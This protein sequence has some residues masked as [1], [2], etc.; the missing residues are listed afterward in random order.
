MSP[1]VS[2][3]HLGE[4]AVAFR[5]VGELLGEVVLP[6]PMTRRTLELGAA[7]SPEAAC[8]PFKYTLG[9]FIE[10]LEAG[11][12]VIVQAGGGCRLG[13]YGEVQEAILRDLGYDFG[14]MALSNH[15]TS[16]RKLMREFKRLNPR[17]SFRSVSRAFALAAKKVE[18][19]DAM[20]AVVRRDSA[21]AAD[22]AAYEGAFRDFLRELDSAPTPE[23][24]EE[25]GRT[26]LARLA[27]AELRRP[28]RPL[29]VGVVGEFYVAV[30]P[31]SN[32]SL[33]RLLAAEGVEVHRR[34]S[35]SGVFEA[36]YGGKRYMRDLV[37]SAAPYLTHDIGVD[38]TKSIAHTLAYMR[39]GFDGVV[40]V[41]PFG[42][43]PE[44]NAA[45]ALHRLARENGF[46]VMSLSYDVHT[47]ETGTRTR[48]EAFCEML[49]RRRR[50]PASASAATRA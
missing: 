4:Y 28:E 12:E 37:A 50:A 34:V 40:H 38:G 26:G 10:A 23:A 49:R 8:V 17:N 33:E 9:C 47:S 45:P 32:H 48:V 3:P 27:A 41:R 25:T 21:F 11:A 6:P 20:E 18:V 2:F 31:F 7:H 16:L 19:L 39:D 22:P 35:V 43:M 46:P 1:V 13:F 42:C 36:V 44:V 29:R 15:S 5:P 30:E 24:A 14:F